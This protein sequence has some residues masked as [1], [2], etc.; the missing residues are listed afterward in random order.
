MPLVILV[1]AY[2]DYALPAFEL[3]AVDYLLK[4]YSDGRFH[5]ALALARARLEADRLERVRRGVLALAQEAELD[6][7]PRHPSA[8]YLTRLTIRTDTGVSIVPVR[9]IA[10][11]EAAGDH[12]R[13]HLADRWLTLRSTM[14]RLER[15]LD[16]ARFVRIH[17][18]TIVNVDWVRELRSTP[19]EGYLAVLR[20]G[21]TRPI[22]GRGREQ[23]SR[24]L[25]FQ[26]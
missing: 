22:S 23:L 9:E 21:T 6:P 26:L 19:A 13:V 8:A 10:W 5:A 20:D 11:I 12:A 15:R 7:S 16:P 14:D 17:R 2:E 4:P 24:V 3:H 25:D 18:S 1:T